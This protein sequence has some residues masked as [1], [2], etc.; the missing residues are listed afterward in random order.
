MFQQADDVESIHG[1]NGMT[2]DHMTD[3]PADDNLNMEQMPGSQTI[4][5]E[6]EISETYE[7]A[8]E[9]VITIQ[10]SPSEVP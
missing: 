9:T 2:L 1:V 5:N 10:I 8:P 6:H 7:G 3:L 4:L